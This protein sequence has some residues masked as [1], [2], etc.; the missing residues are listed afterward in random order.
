VGEQDRKQPLEPAGIFGMGRPGGEREC[1]ENVL[2]YRCAGQ[3][4]VFGVSV[5]YPPPRSAAAGQVV[6]SD[7]RLERVVV[8]IKVIRRD[9]SVVHDGPEPSSTPRP[10]WGCRTRRPK[11]KVG[12]CTK[13]PW[14]GT[15][16]VC[17]LSGPKDADGPANGAANISAR[18]RGSIRAGTGRSRWS[19]SPGNPGC[20]VSRETFGGDA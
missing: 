8:L 3:E 20:R 19:Q 14:L 10:L 1:A 5:P 7:S 2:T 17:P 9:S 18:G 13:P 12:S 4:N 16:W 6:A 11:W 15:G